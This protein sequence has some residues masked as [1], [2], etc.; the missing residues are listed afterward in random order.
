MVLATI[1]SAIGLGGSRYT[2][3]AAE[4]DGREA[5]L[6]RTIARNG[7]VGL[8]CMAVSLAVESL[9]EA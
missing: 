9:I 5:L 3:T 1:A 4:R 6:G 2:E 8:T 7:T